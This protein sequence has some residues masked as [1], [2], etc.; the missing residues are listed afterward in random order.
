MSL[1]TFLC[2]VTIVALSVSQYVTSKKL[3]QLRNENATLKKD[4]CVLEVGD[5]NLIHAVQLPVF[6]SDTYRFRLHLPPQ[7]TYL[8]KYATEQISKDGYPKNAKSQRIQANNSSSEPAELVIRRDKNSLG[9]NFPNGGAM[10]TSLRPIDR[11]GMSYST[12]KGVERG[13]IGVQKPGKPFLLIRKRT[14]YTQTKNGLGEDDIPEL[15]ESGLLFW[16][17]EVPNSAPPATTSTNTPSP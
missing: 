7:K 14:V 6:E 5:P 10:I 3:N 12:F 11:N 15:A 2:L 1:A 13:K 8:L 17:E 4:F 9:I 16:I